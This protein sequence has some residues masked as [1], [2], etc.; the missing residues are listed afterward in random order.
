ME[1]PASPIATP[2]PELFPPPPPPAPKPMTNGIGP[3]KRKSS[4]KLDDRAE[5]RARTEEPDSMSIG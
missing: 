5:K 1:T 2:R 3:E 4:P